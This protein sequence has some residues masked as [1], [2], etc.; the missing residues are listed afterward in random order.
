MD[1]E[2]ESFDWPAHQFM[3]DERHGL[4]VHYLSADNRQPINSASPL[5]VWHFDKMNSENY[6]RPTLMFIMRPV[7]NDSLKD[8]E[9]YRW[10]VDFC[11][12]S[13]INLVLIRVTN[14][15][16]TKLKL[17]NIQYNSQFVLA[18]DGPINRLIDF[19]SNRSS[20]VK[21]K[22]RAIVVL[23]DRVHSDEIINQLKESSDEIVQIV[24]YG[25]DLDQN[26]DTVITTSENWRNWYNKSFVDLDLGYRLN[27]GSMESVLTELRTKLSIM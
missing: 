19:L 2:S 8:L 14:E 5:Q 16:I 26:G 7:L 3:T 23:N 4:S 12:R 6:R 15:S 9:R 13:H 10:L 27:D 1:E 22:Y 18:T 11:R 20:T 25:R 17:S 21:E 24:N